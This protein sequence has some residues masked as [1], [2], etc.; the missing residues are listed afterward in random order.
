MATVKT[1]IHKS[2]QGS[3]VYYNGLDQDCD[4]GSDY[5]A[6]GDGFDSDQHGGTDCDDTDATIS[7]AANDDTLDGI[8]NNCDGQI[9]EG[10]II[11]DN[12]GDGF[13]NADGDCDDSNPNVN[14]GATDDL[15]RWY[16]PRLL[17]GSDYDQ[18][19]DG[20]DATSSGGTDCDDTDATIYVG[21]T[22]F[23]GT[24]ERTKIVMQQ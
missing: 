15:V 6:D 7:P 23:G 16:R 10:V 19:N 24:T 9:D 22:E 2:I 18:D 3:E 5:D 12:D 11:V 21:A 8:D 17:C 13:T 20:F 1:W 14:P 4:Q